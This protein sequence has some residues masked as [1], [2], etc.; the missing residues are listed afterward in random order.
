MA[1]FVGNEFRKFRFVFASGIDYGEKRA[2]VDQIFVSYQG[3]K[4]FGNF[5]FKTTSFS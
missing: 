4:S 5:Y 2:Q 3:A 1:V